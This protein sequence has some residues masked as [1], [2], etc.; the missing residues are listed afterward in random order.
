MNLLQSAR[1]IFL[2][3]I[4]GISKWDRILLQN[5]LGNKKCYRNVLQNALGIQN[6]TGI[7]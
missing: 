1:N 3:N 4:L 6:A 7:Y 2:E 5:V